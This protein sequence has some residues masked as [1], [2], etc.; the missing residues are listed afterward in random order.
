MCGLRVLG[1]WREKGKLKAGE[2]SVKSRE[3][4]VKISYMSVV[5]EGE[6]LPDIPHLAMD[7]E[8]QGGRAE[9][10]PLSGHLSA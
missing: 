1:S 6:T 9:P 10:W 5:T 4:S 7:K 8:I 2:R 3:E